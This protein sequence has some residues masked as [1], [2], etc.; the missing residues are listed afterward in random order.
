MTAQPT[1]IC[2]ATCVWSAAESTLGHRMAI[3][4]GDVTVLACRRHAPTAGRGFP[5]VAEHNWCGDYFVRQAAQ[6]A[7]ERDN[8]AADMSE[9]R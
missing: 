7:P 9:C 3:H 4:P 6:D 1:P 5:W 2:C 8:T